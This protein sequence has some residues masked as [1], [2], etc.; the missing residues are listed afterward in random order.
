MND[1]HQRHLFHTVQHMDELLSEA[2]QILATA[3]SDSP[4]KK[5]SQDTTPIQRRVTHDYI[6]RVRQVFHRIL[7]ELKIPPAQPICGALWGARCSV[8]FAVID[9]AEID[10]RHMLGYGELS[11]DDVRTLERIVAELNAEL[12]RVSGFL[13]AGSAADLQARLNRLESAQEEIKLLHEL[14]RIITAHGLVELR[15]WLQIL[16]ER[17]EARSFEIGVFGRVSSGKSSLL[18]YLLEQ[19]VL[20]VGVTPVT[21]V[22]TRISYG[23]ETKAT[24]EFVEKPFLSVSLQSLPEFSTEQENPGNA[25]HVAGIRIEVPARRLR[26]GVAFVDTPGLG[27][28]A[29][30]GAEETMAYLPK[31]DLGIVLLDAGGSLGHEDLVIVEAL[32]RSGASAMV[33]VSKA[34]LLGESD[35]QKMKDYVRHHIVSELGF[36]LPVHLVSVVGADAQTSDKWFEASLSPIFDT[37]RDRSAATFRRKVTLLKEAAADGLRVRLKMTNGEMGHSRPGE[38]KRA[39]EAL[40][41]ANTVL[42]EA[43]KEGRKLANAFRSLSSAVLQLASVE[44]AAAWE[45][46][47]GDERALFTLCLSRF[48]T[49]KSGLFLESVRSA[50][51]KLAS[52]LQEA[53]AAL[54]SRGRLPDEL[55][56]AGEL[57]SMDCTI[58]ANKVELE[59]PTLWSVLGKKWMQ[60]FV[61]TRLSRQIGGLTDEFFDLG[62]KR[63]DQWHRHALNEL[64]KAFNARAGIYRTQTDGG[65]SNLIAECNSGEIEADLNLL[66]NWPHADA[67][68]DNSRTQS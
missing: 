65:E 26:D 48:L 44:I 9:V 22:P 53:E 30:S 40:R 12:N 36:E 59:R 8:D 1:N 20:P 37:H 58:I 54:V 7:E 32:F 28:L 50:R 41:S 49:Q 57:P 38:L 60:H 15:Q 24:I 16:V 21:A 46:K 10:A 14:S 6:S 29:T 62:A 68:Y 61:V 67:D 25:K 43:E 5:Y 64:R 34:D 27:S 39:I 13:A 55:P 33:L 56:N 2:E 3:G 17:A 23:T 47:T 51:L 63:L 52:V 18:N 45:N 31:C 19:S 42:E 66:Q 35:R 11:D 4:F